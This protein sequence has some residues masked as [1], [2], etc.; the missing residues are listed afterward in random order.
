MASIELADD[1]DVLLDDLEKRTG[2]SKAFYVREAVLNYVEELKDVE[3]AE[4]RYAD[5]L[6]GRSHTVPL[7]KV[8]RR[9]DVLAEESTDR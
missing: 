6:A 9:Y 1:V 4:Q 3:I 7:E 5:L 8:M 2:K